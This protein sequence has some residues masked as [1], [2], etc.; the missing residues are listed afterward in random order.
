MSGHVSQ[1]AVCV[2]ASGS[3]CLPTGRCDSLHSNYGSALFLRSTLKRWFKV[4]L[5]HGSIKSK[6]AGKTDIA[7]STFPWL[8]LHALMTVSSW[9][10]IRDM[11]FTL[12]RSISSNLLEK[13]TAISESWWTLMS[14]RKKS[15]IALVN[16]TVLNLA[17]FLGLHFLA[18]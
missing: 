15:K 16:Y 7:G 8:S 18:F 6:V 9:L 3:A 14:N 1:G 5:A 13:V 2:C 17:C 11:S 12:V 10:K 4:K